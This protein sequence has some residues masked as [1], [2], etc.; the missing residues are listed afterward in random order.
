MI[1]VALPAMVYLTIGRMESLTQG[2]LR[3][4]PHGAASIANTSFFL[5][6]PLNLVAI[7]YLI[8]TAK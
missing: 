6:T 4:K 1:I 2:I 8:V 3:F 7:K 5:W